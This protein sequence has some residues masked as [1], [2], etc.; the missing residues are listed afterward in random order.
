ME[1]K[2]KLS[3]DDY[4]L[5]L[6]ESSSNASQTNKTL[7]F[8][9]TVFSL[10]MV[11]KVLISEAMV[12]SDVVLF[13]IG[14]FIMNLPKLIFYNEVRRTLKSEYINDLTQEYDIRFSKNTF[15]I[16]T[17]D[18]EFESSYS[19]TQGIYETDNFLVIIL[20]EIRHFPILKNSLSLSDSNQILNYFK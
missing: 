17:S 7:F 5:F 15:V 14:L 8:L 2:S 6:K 18:Q 9:G 1:I 10:S 19:D 11:V 12:V 4:V 3:I 13:A 20:N 16:S